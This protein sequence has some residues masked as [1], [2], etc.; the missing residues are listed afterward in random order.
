MSTFTCV[1]DNADAA[2]KARL[3][4]CQA[5]QSA[6][7]GA[8]QMQAL[9][10]SMKAITD[11]SKEITEILKNIDEIAFQTNILA[12]PLRTVHAVSFN[13]HAECYFRITLDCPVAIQGLDLRGLDQ[14]VKP[15][16]SGFGRRIHDLERPVL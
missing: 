3:T 16:T 5:R 1:H 14:L 7:T 9:L 10:A 12:A 11:A 4:A 13:V 15:H 8:T 6:D 2:Q